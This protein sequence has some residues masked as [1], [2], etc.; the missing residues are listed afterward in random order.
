[1]FACYR[2]SALSWGPGECTTGTLTWPEE[3][4]RN[5]P[6]K[7]EG[8]VIEAQRTAG[9]EAQRLGKPLVCFVKQVN[10]VCGVFV[11]PCLQQQEGSEWVKTEVEA[12]KITLAT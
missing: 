9:A 2:C 10:G 3:V 6:R 7:A 1:M 11:S 4:C 5:Y 8:E 12:L